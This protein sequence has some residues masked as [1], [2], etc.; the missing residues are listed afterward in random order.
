[1]REQ[2]QQERLREHGEAAHARRALLPAHEVGSQPDDAEQRRDRTD[3]AAAPLGRHERPG[4]DQPEPGGE[5]GGRGAPGT[6]A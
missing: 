1:M 2:G 4:D 6:A 5:V 3:R